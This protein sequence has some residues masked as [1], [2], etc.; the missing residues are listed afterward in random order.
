LQDLP[1]K[2]PHWRS[3]NALKFMDLMKLMPFIPWNE[4]GWYTNPSMG[5]KH[6]RCTRGRKRRNFG[7]D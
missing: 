4:R 6:V 1:P 7:I 5:G 3:L 2:Y